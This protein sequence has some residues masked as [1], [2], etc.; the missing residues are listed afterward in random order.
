M[1]DLTKPIR[2]LVTG[3]D[4]QGLACIVQDGPSPAV[5]TV[6]ERPGYRVTNL[7]CTAA[8]AACDDADAVA[9]HVGVLPPKGGTILRII[10]V[11]PEPTDA[12]ARAAAVQATFRDMFRD[13]HQAATE[14][15]HPA[16]HRT[17]T[18]D[19][20]IV[21]AGTITAI[22]ETG[23]TDMRAGDVLVQRGTVHAWAN[24]S[25]EPARIAFVLIDPSRGEA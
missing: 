24:R 4:A 1:N 18:I 17:E 25:G 16:M 20:A 6:A 8:G 23:E 22:L 21:L 3:T 2:R 11:P 14:Q 5:L 19:Y 15:S 10:D 13:A 9:A 7:W 12:A